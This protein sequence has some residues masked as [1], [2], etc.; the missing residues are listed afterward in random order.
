MKVEKILLGTN[1]RGKVLRGVAGLGIVAG[2]IYGINSRV[3]GEANPTTVAR[4]E[5]TVTPTATATVTPKAT[6]VAGDAEIAGNSFSIQGIPDRVDAASVDTAKDIFKNTIGFGSGMIVAE[7]GVLK[8][9]W[10]FP[11]AQFDAAEGHIYH[12]DS[13]NQFIL[14]TPE[15]SVNVPEGAFAM[16]NGNAMIIDVAGNGSASFHLEIPGPEAN[17]NIV[18]IRGLYPDGSTPADRNRIAK[19]T[20]YTPGAVLYDMYPKGGFVSEGQVK[21]IAKN[22][23]TSSPNC[24]AEACKTVTMHELDAN[25]GALVVVKTSDQGETWI[26]VF[27]NIN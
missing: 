24:G 21:Q 20:G 15:S 5:S 27:S 8:V 22:A 7:P 10:D 6:E 16:L 26:G 12:Y 19:L 4:V 11:K 9:G 13:G 3:H 14:Q 1:F 18:I 25:T 23:S 17:H 2:G